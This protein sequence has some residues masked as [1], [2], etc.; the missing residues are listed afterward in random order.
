M[1]YFIAVAQ[2]LHSQ[3]MNF[4]AHPRTKVYK[5]KKKSSNILY[6]FIMIYLPVL[7]VVEGDSKRL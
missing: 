4:A 1:P 2:L 7:C 6:Y 5:K 3:P